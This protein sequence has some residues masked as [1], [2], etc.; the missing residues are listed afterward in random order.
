MADEG[1][2][3]SSSSGSAA[4]QR[5]LAVLAQQVAL[6]PT[7]AASTSSYASIDGRP[8]SYA[9]VHGAVSRSPATWRSIPVVARET[10]QEVLYDKAV[11]EGIAKVGG[12]MRSRVN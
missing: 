10:L 7:A 5:R 8:S 12:A 11:G 2:G 4:A 1:G 9:R 3:S 6:Q